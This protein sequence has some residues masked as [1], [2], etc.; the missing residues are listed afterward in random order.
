VRA[1]KIPHALHIGWQFSESSGISNTHSCLGFDILLLLRW[2]LLV[3]PM[4]ILRVMGL[5]IK[6]LL[7]LDIFLDVLSFAGLLI[8]NIQ[9]PNPP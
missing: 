3:F 2:I 5:I 8:N 9:L 6:S 1:F 7:G 4:S